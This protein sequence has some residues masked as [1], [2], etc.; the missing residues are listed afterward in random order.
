MW[1]NSGMVTFA[2]SA[3]CGFPPRSADVLSEHCWKSDFGIC[4]LSLP[5]SLCRHIQMFTSSKK[6]SSE[7][8]HMQ[9]SRPVLTSLLTRSTQWRYESLVMVAFSEER[10][11]WEIRPVVSQTLKP[12]KLSWNL[13]MEG[14][15]SEF[16]SPAVRESWC[17]IV[18]RHV[19]EKCFVVLG[20]WR[21]FLEDW[22]TPRFLFGLS[23]SALYC[24]SPLIYPKLFEENAE[25]LQ[26]LWQ[27]LQKS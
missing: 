10:E 3:F 5:F 1:V 6:R 20:H 19:F 4:F 16:W 23:G 8:E 22:A 17:I 26:S 24:L 11:F 7:K 14:G 2:F 15:I 9:K 18:S 13:S 27:A 12:K 25:V 21:K